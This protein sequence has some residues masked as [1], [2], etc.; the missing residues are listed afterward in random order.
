[1]AVARYNFSIKAKVRVG[2]LIDYPFCTAYFDD[3]GDTDAKAFATYLESKLANE[4]KVGVSK[5]VVEGAEGEIATPADIKDTEDRQFILCNST[6]KNKRFLL[7]IP[8]LLHASTTGDIGTKSLLYP[9]GTAL[10]KTVQVKSLGKN[11]IAGG[12]V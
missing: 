11:V 12:D 9:D 5:I 3:A 4:A 2:R 6:D 8:G 1:M 10:D 7:T